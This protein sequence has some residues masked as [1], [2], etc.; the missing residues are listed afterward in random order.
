MPQ[1]RR[2]PSAVTPEDRRLARR[3]ARES[4]AAGRVAA[5][6]ELLHLKALARRERVLRRAHRHLRQ[7]AVGAVVA[8]AA[9]LFEP[10]S[11]P[12]LWVLAA[13]FALR[14]VHAFS[15]LRQPPVVPTAPASLQLPRTPPPPS[16]QS[17]AFPAVRRLEDARAAMARLAPLVAPAGREVADEAWRTASDADTALRWQAA[18]LA[19]VEPHRG[20]EPALIDLLY[21]GVV[22]Q[23]RL[24]AGMADLVSASADP[25]AVGRLQDATDALNGLAQGLREVR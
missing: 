16:P 19:A 3:L 14:A 10:D 21:S 17:A 25:H 24:V 9:T 6:A 22:A 11:S 7:G 13:L 12:V 2:R 4:R 20:A 5:R 23:E 18:R 1:R 8:A 15:T